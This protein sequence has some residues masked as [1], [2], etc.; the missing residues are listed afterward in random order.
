MAQELFDSH[1]HSGNSFD[2]CDPVSVMCDSAIKK[3]ISG[4][5]ITDH[6]E[7]RGYYTERYIDVVENSAADIARA[8]RDFAGRLEVSAG[9]EI[10]DVFFD[11]ALTEKVLSGH[12][13]DMVIVSQ[14]NAANGEDVYYCKFKEWTQSE[15]NAY[16]DFYFNYLLRIAKWNRFDT[17]A[18][19]TYPI[20]YITGMHQIK[21]DLSRWDDVIDELLKTVAQNGRAIEVNTS[22]LWQTLGDTMPPYRYIRRY[23]ELGGEYITIGSDSHAAVN[24]GR[25][26]TDAL[27]LLT[28]A[29]FRHY[30]FFKSHQ[31]MQIA[32]I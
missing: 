25:G 11:E 6:C 19:L 5:C 1:M 7:M 14:H 31:P 32:I 10:S 28:D 20:R 13:F 23:R 16:L 29:G 9:I 12:T 18:H 15:L 24:V 30:T 26:L 4:V 22:G 17:I 27:K 2:A 8:K 3:G 21:V